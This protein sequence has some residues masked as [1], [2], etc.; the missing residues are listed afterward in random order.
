MRTGKHI[1]LSEWIT[2]IAFV[3]MVVST[4]AQVV[5]RYLL[6]Y[7][8]P[9]ADELARFSLVW[10]V[11][12]GMVA[13]LARGQHVTADVLLERYRGRM[14]LIMLTLVDLAS[15]LL[16][17]CLLYGGVKL[18]EM[19]GT[20]MTASLGVP[21]SW[22]YAALPIGATLMLIELLLQIVR[23]LRQPASDSDAPSDSGPRAL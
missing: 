8:L 13:T 23:R 7:S 18:V 3:A 12:V 19:T 16:F 22:I 1:L 21:K 4:C 15:I 20:Q 5:C 17:G 9:W 14:R 2:I 11:F 10:M 6:S